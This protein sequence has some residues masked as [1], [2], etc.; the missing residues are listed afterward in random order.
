M[1]T[2][3]KS[4]LLFIVAEILLTILVLSNVLGRKLFCQKQCAF[5]LNSAH[6][7]ILGMHFSLFALT[8]FIALLFIA[9]TVLYYQK[10]YNI[11][12]RASFFGAIIAIYFLYLQFFI[13]KKFCLLCI[14]INTLMLVIFLESYILYADNKKS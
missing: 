3:E 13:L 9:L 4:I 7:T 6:S 1:K 12:L 2:L 11:L 8:A 5:V 10:N 14:A